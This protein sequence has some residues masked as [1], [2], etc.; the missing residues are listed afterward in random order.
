VRI[1]I[2]DGVF[3]PDS[4]E[5]RLQWQPTIGRLIEELRKAPS[6]LHLSYLADLESEGLVRERVDSLKK[7]IADQWQN[8]DGGYLLAVEKDIFWRRGAPRHGRK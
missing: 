5:L 2:A 4:S 6:V 7:M 3:D 8:S 1:D